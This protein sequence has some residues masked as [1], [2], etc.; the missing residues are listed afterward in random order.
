MMVA[1]VNAA[2]SETSIMKGNNRLSI[3]YSVSK[4]RCLVGSFL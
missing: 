3:L 2:P 1:A 4:M